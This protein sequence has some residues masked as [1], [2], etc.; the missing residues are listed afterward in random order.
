VSS[1]SLKQKNNYFAS[2]FVSNNSLYNSLAKLTSLKDHPTP[3][4]S[5]FHYRESEQH[6]DS[7]NVFSS[8]FLLSTSFTYSST[9]DL[10]DSDYDL[11]DLLLYFMY[12]SSFSSSSPTFSNP[13]IDSPTSM[14]RFL[15]FYRQPIYVFSSPSFFYYF[16]KQP[17]S[18][19]H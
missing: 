16:L 10:S 19:S 4:S 5:V 7:K 9:E 8:L 11:E 17:S 14:K 18:K 12:R 1:Y 13:T 6:L 15:N 2:G 3:F